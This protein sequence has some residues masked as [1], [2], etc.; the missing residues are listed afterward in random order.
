M[1]HA[2]PICRPMLVAVEGP[3][4]G[5]EDKP[6]KGRGF[7][8]AFGSWFGSGLD[9]DLIRTCISGHNSTAEKGEYH[10][11]DNDLPQREVS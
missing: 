5:D 8:P 10:A 9:R 2:S 11:I 3:V 4:T 6:G 1:K 7:R